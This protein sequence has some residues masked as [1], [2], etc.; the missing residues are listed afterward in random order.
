[1]LRSL[2]PPT[3]RS[4][5][6]SLLPP[7]L[8]KVALLRSGR[9]IG[10]QVFSGHKAEVCAAGVSLFSIPPL[11]QEDS[12]VPIFDVSENTPRIALEMAVDVL[13]M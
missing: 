9:S 3:F 13:L 7:L 4:F 5:L 6:R 10:K 8:N 2:A 12:C 11:H 1:M